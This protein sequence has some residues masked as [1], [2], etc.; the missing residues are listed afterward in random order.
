MAKMLNYQLSIIK[1]DFPYI[2]M[3]WNV[4]RRA[5]HCEPTAGRRTRYALVPRVTGDERRFSLAF[6]DN[7][8]HNTI[9][10]G[11]TDSLEPSG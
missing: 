5:C 3:L 9:G 4:T 7:P 2:R 8:N 1:P 10:R 11:R 6:A